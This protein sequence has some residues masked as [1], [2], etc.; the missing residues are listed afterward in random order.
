MHIDVEWMI[1]PVLLT[2]HFALQ[3]SV[4]HICQEL[5]N[6]E[7]EYVH[8]LQLLVKVNYNISHSKGSLPL[9]ERHGYPCH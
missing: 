9:V 4:Y 3:V 5:L 8:R 2:S 6:T 7:E 1:N